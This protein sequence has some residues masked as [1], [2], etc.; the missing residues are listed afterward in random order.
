MEHWKNT[1]KTLN[2]LREKYLETDSVEFFKKY[3]YWR[4]IIQIL[5]ESYKQLRTVDLNYEVL[6]QIVKYRKG[7]KLLEW[8]MF[9]NEISKL[10]LSKELIFCE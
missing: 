2:S 10:P 6:A 1:I 9:L 4:E 7:H 8:G 5:P 3:Q